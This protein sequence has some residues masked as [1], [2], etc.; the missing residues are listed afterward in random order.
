MKVHIL[1]PDG[2]AGGTLYNVGSVEEENGV[3][4]CRM[5][6]TDTAKTLPKGAFVNVEA[7]EADEND[8]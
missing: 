2:S 3:L 4:V 6:F 1:L 7:D 5:I 8:E